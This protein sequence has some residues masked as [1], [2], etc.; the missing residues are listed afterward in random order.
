[1]TR[2]R[3]EKKLQ[4]DLLA[5]VEP[6]FPGIIVEVGAVDRWD[7]PCASFCWPGF[8]QLLPEE[9]FHRLA[10]VIPESFITER[11]G[12]FIWLELALGESIDDFLALP[13]SED[14]ADREKEI[15]SQLVQAGFFDAL[16]KTMGPSPD[17]LCLGDFRHL[18]QV[19]Q[20]KQ[21]TAKQ[22]C[23]T[24]LIL[25]HHHAFCDCQVLLSALSSLAE[26]YAGAA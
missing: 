25:I 5:M 6:K 24:K 26:Q 7:R 10:T 21:F 18:S 19:L 3:N 13:R 12:G 14:V 15:Y 11:L 4:A 22:M 2:T 16:T 23:D 17:K 8:A 1:M 20:A 9:R